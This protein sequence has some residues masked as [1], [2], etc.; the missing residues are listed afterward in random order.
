MVKTKIT[1]T[2]V[3]RIGEPCACCAR[4]RGPRAV[5]GVRVDVRSEAFTYYY[6]DV[7]IGQLAKAKAHP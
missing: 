4:E 3:N 7:C 1:F 6:C 5:R 2:P